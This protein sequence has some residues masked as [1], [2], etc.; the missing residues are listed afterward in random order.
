MCDYNKKFK[1]KKECID[2]IK[3]L[4]K[5]CARLAGDTPPSWVVYADEFDNLADKQDITNERLL[6]ENK[7]MRSN[8]VEY[9]KQESDLKFKWN[10]TVENLGKEKETR[11]DLE[12]KLTK[13][14][15]ETNDI[16]NVMFK[17]VMKI[18]GGQ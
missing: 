13:A 14:E 3:R 12:W 1:T 10:R 9:Q 17:L 6:A 5:E 11:R 7:I 2:E 8:I 4:E 15:Q 16:K 18:Y